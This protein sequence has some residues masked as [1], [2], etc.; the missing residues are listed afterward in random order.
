M[1]LIPYLRVDLSSF[2][3]SNND[4]LYLCNIFLKKMSN[5]DELGLNL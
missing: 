1:N 3:L 2:N 5:L 4:I